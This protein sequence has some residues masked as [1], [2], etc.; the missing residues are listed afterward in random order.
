M[1]TGNASQSSKFSKLQSIH[2]AFTEKDSH[3]KELYEFHKEKT[4]INSNNEV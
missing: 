1:S 3:C 4:T 2:L